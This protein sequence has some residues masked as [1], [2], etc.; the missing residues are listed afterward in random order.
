MSVSVRA[1]QRGRARAKDALECAR[2]LLRVSAWQRAQGGREGGAEEERDRGTHT[3]VFS[4]HGGRW[5][6]GD[7]S[8]KVL[9]E[10]MYKY[11]ERGLTV[12]RAL[13]FAMLHLLHRR[14]AQEEEG[15]EGGFSDTTRPCSWSDGPKHWAA[16]VVVGAST[17]LQQ[18]PGCTR[19]ARGEPLAATRQAAGNSYVQHKRWRERAARKAK[20][21]L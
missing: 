21:R 13:R 7:K 5:Q 6:V 9:M 14:P 3:C 18:P 17:R 16:F 10:I 4:H 2:L 12:P 1:G 19:D 15:R 8:T 11:L 20:W